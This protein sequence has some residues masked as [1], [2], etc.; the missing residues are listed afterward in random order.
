VVPR[1]ARTFVDPVTGQAKKNYQQV[2]RLGGARI[3]NIRRKEGQ[4]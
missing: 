2:N 1:L 3:E 4:G